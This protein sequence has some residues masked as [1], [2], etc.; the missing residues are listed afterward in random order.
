MQRHD[1]IGEVVAHH[2]T[3]IGCFRP[4]PGVEQLHGFVEPL[5]A[6]PRGATPVVLADMNNVILKVLEGIVGIL[7][8]FQIAGI[9][10]Q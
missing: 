8:T 4:L 1:G 7:G 2:A 10:F 3:S 5:H 9:V 6:L